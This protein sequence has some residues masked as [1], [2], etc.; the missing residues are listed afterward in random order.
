MDAFDDELCPLGSIQQTAYT[1]LFSS[2]KAGAPF[3][4]RRDSHLTK[5]YTPLTGMYKTTCP[6]ASMASCLEKEEAD[7][8]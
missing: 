8:K 2:N 1:F 4:R 6:A 7:I 5:F 3:F